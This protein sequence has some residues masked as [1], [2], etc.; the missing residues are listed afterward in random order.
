MAVPSGSWPLWDPF[1]GFGQPILANPDAQ[2]LYPLTWLNLLM[3]PATYYTDF[4]VSHLV[5]TGLGMHKLS[6]RL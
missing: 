2:D 4:A 5:Y 6:L 3:S 1:T